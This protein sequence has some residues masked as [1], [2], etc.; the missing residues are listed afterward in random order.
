MQRKQTKETIVGEVTEPLSQWAVTLSY[1]P[2]TIK[3]EKSNIIEPK[4][5]C[6]NWTA[7]DLHPIL[8]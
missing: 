4:Q 5:K 2:K 6:N 3:K 8:K 1:F 7:G